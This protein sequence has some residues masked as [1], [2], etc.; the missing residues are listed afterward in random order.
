[1]SNTK[2]N[3]GA[4]LMDALRTH[5][6][7]GEGYTVHELRR[8][9]AEMIEELEQERA[10][11]GVI[12]EYELI[13][14]W[15]EE[16]GH[17]HDGSTTWRVIDREVPGDRGYEQVYEQGTTSGFSGMDAGEAAV[18]QDVESCGWELTS[19]F[20]YG[21]ILGDSQADVRRVP[22]KDS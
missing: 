22:K 9:V 6:G 1:M 21:M 12:T 4:G 16:Y 20:K 14:D 10:A 17:G 8:H 15:G 7:D 11:A 3:T 19:S 13:V 18:K 2:E 5:L